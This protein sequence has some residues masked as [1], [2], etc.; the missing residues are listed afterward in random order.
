MMKFTQ[1]ML[2]PFEGNMRLLNDDQKKLAREE[3]LE[4]HKDKDKKATMAGDFDEE[5]FNNNKEMKTLASQDISDLLTNR[6]LYDMT[7]NLEIK[8]GKDG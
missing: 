4:T 1:L 6:I 8:E 5:I 2:Y 3:Y 7:L